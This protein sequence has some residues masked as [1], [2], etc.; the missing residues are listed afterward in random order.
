[1]LIVYVIVVPDKSKGFLMLNLMMDDLGGKDVPAL[2]VLMAVRTVFEIE[3]VFP[4][5]IIIGCVHW[6][7]SRFWNV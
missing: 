6:K 7:Q 2:T 4:E 3:T 5:I 1:M